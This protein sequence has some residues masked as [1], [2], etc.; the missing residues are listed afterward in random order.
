MEGGRRGQK[1]GARIEKR[2]GGKNGI[3]GKEKKRGKRNT[4]MDG[5][6]GYGE[7]GVDRGE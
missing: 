6:K 4:R 7:R 2:K 1:G 5:R 3:G